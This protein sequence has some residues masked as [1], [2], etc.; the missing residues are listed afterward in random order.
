MGTGENMQE[1]TRSASTVEVTVTE[2]GEVVSG[3]F[4][5]TFGFTVAGRALIRERLDKIDESERQ[6]DRVAA[7]VQLR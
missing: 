7:Q 1:R 5:S 6:A 3:T 4:A 2:P